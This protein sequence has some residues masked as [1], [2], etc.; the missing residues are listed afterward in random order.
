[1]LFAK[2]H[3]DARSLQ[4]ATSLVWP[5]SFERFFRRALARDPAA[6]FPDADSMSRAWV[7]VL[8]G[9]VH[10]LSEPRSTVRGR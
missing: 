7:R 5:A 2:E 4:E 6:R 10:E 3:R 1:M 9:G 8:E